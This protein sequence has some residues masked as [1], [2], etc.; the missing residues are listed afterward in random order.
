MATHKVLWLEGMLL[1]PQHL[2]SARR[3]QKGEAW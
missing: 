3:A 2:S 1:R